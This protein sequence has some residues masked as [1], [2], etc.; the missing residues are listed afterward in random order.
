MCTLP[1]HAV[2]NWWNSSSTPDLDV[3]LETPH[4]SEPVSG[5]GLQRPHTRAFT[6]TSNA[7]PAYSQF[8]S[9]AD[10]RAR[11]RAALED[12]DAAQAKVREWQAQHRIAGPSGTIRARRRAAENAPNAEVAPDTLGR[13]TRR[14]A[15]RKET[16]QASGVEQD[17]PLPSK[18]EPHHEIWLPP[19]SAYED[20]AQ[21]EVRR[22]KSRTPSSSIP[23]VIPDAATPRAA[24]PVQASQGTNGVDE[25][26]LYPP[27]PAAYPPTPLPATHDLP[28]VHIAPLP[29][30]PSI[31]E[32][33][34]DTLIH[35][36]T[37]TPPL[38]HGNGDHSAMLS[39]ESLQSP[40][41]DLLRPENKIF[42]QDF[43]GSLEPSPELS[44]PSSLGASSDVDDTMTG[45]QQTGENSNLVSPVGDTVD[46]MPWTRSRLSS[47]VTTRTVSTTTSSLPSRSTA[48]TTAD[49]GSSLRTRKASNASTWITDT[50]SSTGEERTRSKTIRSSPAASTAPHRTGLRSHKT[51]AS[52]SSL[53]HTP[54]AK[55]R[56]KAVQKYR[57]I[58]RVNEDKTKVEASTDATIE[59]DT[60][61]AEESSEEEGSASKK[62]KVI[63]P[64]PL[65]TI[66]ETAVRSSSTRSKRKIPIASEIFPRTEE[67]EVEGENDGRGGPAN[68]STRPKRVTCLAGSSRA[69]L[70]PPGKS[71]NAID[72]PDQPLQKSARPSAASR[73]KGG[74]IQ[75]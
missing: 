58:R 37:S 27:F 66:S 4:G 59:D 28:S 21:G 72:A 26:R 36:E 20:H 10:K 33:D 43:G 64:K 39:Q 9:E 17:R 14:S 52:G 29:I 57:T 32:V 40:G 3:L 63:A 18:Q 11:A 2:L 69:P 13:G 73:G 75:R 7:D 35:A 30:P 65:A 74:K 16:A 49:D 15:R 6:G 55:R 70:R 23:Q 5:E 19:A 71:N 38:F 53:Q 25:W 61:F 22:P 56:R 60:E 62:R 41:H 45:V 12:I 68:P 44:I 31:A 54:N 24:T 50:S 1:F 67:P 42:E 34:V 48:L 51:T 47:T 8:Q 46:E